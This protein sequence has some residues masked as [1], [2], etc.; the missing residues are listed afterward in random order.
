MGRS[1]DRIE[2]DIAYLEQ[3]TKTSAQELHSAYSSYLNDLGQAMRKQLILASYQVCTQGYPKSFLKLSYS[4]Q[5]QLQKE[6]RM[7]A[8]SA[9]QMLFSGMHST[10]GK[11]T[12]ELRFTRDGLIMQSHP[13]SQESMADASGDVQK[14]S[15][16][17]PFEGD[18]SPLSV[19]TTEK[20]TKPEQLVKWQ[21]SLEEAI[22][23]ILQTASYKANRLLQQ[24]G[25]L[26]KKLPEPVLEAAAKADASESTPVASPPNL[27]NL[28]IETDSSDRSSG[29]G[30]TQFLA[31]HLRLSE[32]EFADSTVMAG[33]THIRSLSAKISKLGREYE[34]KLRELAVAEAEA[35][36]RASW[37]DE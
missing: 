32:I 10:S 6:L 12:I 22:A 23:K 5:Q 9:M 7:L 24:I 18:R 20:L 14:E 36:W 31:I 11:D 17:I 27:L 35:A 34:K 25:V 4:Q 30:M 16:D 8:N 2:R 13:E 26:P 28:L 37:F 19:E 3:E 21:E 15:D 29:S 33:R 1:I